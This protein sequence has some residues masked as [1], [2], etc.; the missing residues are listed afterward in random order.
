[1]RDSNPSRVDLPLHYLYLI[2]AMPHYPIPATGCKT[3]AA[4]CRHH[5]R[6][7][8]CTTSNALRIG[9]MGILVSEYVPGTGLSTTLLA[10]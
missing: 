1:L 4:G 3:D 9:L 10:N 8:E 5:L 2:P 6:V 7:L